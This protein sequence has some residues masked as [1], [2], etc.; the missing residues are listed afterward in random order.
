MARSED[1][2]SELERLADLDIDDDTDLDA[3]FVDYDRQREDEL[4]ARRR[5]ERARARQAR[6][7]VAVTGT[8]AEAEEA[9][10]RAREPRAHAAIG[11]AEIEGDQ[12]LAWAPAQAPQRPSTRESSVSDRSAAGTDSE[13]DTGRPAEAVTQLPG[14]SAPI[15]DDFVAEM[16]ASAAAAAPVAP[17]PETTS[18]APPLEEGRPETGEPG[19]AVEPMGSAEPE[20]GVG[21]RQAPGGTQT[22]SS[23][24]GAEDDDS[25][26]GEVRSGTA[27]DDEAGVPTVPPA[28]SGARGL[29][30]EA[31]SRSGV[32]WTKFRSWQLQYQLAVGALLL[33]VLLFGL[34]QCFGGSGQQSGM[35]AEQE[36]VQADPGVQVPVETTAAQKTGVLVPSGV[37]SDCPSG[38][39]RPQL[40][41]T[42][43]RRDAWVCTR[44][45]GI[46]GA[47]MTLTFQRPVVISEIEVVPGFNYVEASGI[48]QWTRHRVVTRILWRIGD[49]QILQNINPTRTG[50]TLKVNAIATQQVTLVVQ[51][52]AVPGSKPG[53]SA[54]GANRA[55]GDTFAVSSIKIIG[56]EA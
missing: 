9:S 56:R 53:T 46:D 14:R 26:A 35:E 45:N 15:E 40:A 29:V 16:F 32:Y 49:E 21:A 11:E 48:D 7:A 39:T 6:D 43:E 55:K 47:V 20:P 4:A 1:G 51:S 33:C 38:S 3:L 5:E 18:T 31:R 17:V 10:R 8:A 52:T 27:S 34:V 44:A 36:T 41:F 42:A 37:E 28:L 54:P 25:D 23:S 19:E 2:R 50:A 24:V 30:A 12:V 22:E 13:H